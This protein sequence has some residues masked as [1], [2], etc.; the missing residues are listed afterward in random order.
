[1]LVLR[2]S[3][4]SL[5]SCTWLYV[6]L[7]GLGMCLVLSVLGFTFGGGGG[8]KKPSIEGCLPLASDVSLRG[9]SRLTPEQSQVKKSNACGTEITAG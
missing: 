9:S 7:P 6:A 8:R 3:W 1:M 2:S 4:C 5:C